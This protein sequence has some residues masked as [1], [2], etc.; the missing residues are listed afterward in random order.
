MKKCPTCNRTYSDD[1]LSFCLED[2]ALLSAAYGFSTSEAT[3]V[4]DQLPEIPTQVISTPASLSSKSSFPL[5]Y[6]AILI[7]AILLAGIGVAF[8]YEKQKEVPTIDERN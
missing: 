1:T 4:L 3:L 8:Y 2:G 7:L 5:A 6:L